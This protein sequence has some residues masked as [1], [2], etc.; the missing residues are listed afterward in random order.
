MQPDSRQL[1]KTFRT[2][3]ILLPIALGLGA[4]TYLLLKNFDKEAFAHI[5]WSWSSSFWIMMA[6]FMMVIRD[7]A[8]MIRI[9]ALT[10]DQISWRNS[11][12]VI[13]L[14]EFSS[15]LAPGML[16]GGFFFAIFI[17]NREKVNMGK[18]ITAVMLSSFQDGVFLAIMAPLVY[19]IIGKERLFSTLNL[20][21]LNI[22]KIGS[23]FFYSFWIVYFI[24]L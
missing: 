6:L 19:F 16:G 8:Y 13:M 3:R 1:L 14:W 18:S 21:T 2:S 23:G 17:L 24:I 4:A 22:D 15:A 12:N 7:G 11:F 10:D 9:R 20:E 5:H